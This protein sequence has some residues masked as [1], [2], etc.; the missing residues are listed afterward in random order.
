ML[1]IPREPSDI[2]NNPAAY[3]PGIG[4]RFI[5]ALATGIGTKPPR[6]G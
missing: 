6:I 2:L 1:A 5:V 4:V 3:G